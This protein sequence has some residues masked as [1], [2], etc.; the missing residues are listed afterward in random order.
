MIVRVP[1][2]W[3]QKLRPQI[4]ITIDSAGKQHLNADALLD[5]R[6]EVVIVRHCSQPIQFF[7]FAQLLWRKD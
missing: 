1:D 4:K 5:F 6:M 3:K 2:W 7:L